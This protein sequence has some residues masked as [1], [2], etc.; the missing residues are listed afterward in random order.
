VEHKE[1]KCSSCMSQRFDFKNEH[2]VPP[3]DDRLQKDDALTRHLEAAHLQVPKVNWMKLDATLAE[4]VERK[5]LGVPKDDTLRRDAE[6]AITLHL[7]TH[8]AGSL[9]TE[10]RTKHSEDDASG[11]TEPSR[12]R[13]SR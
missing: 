2:L 10:H 7:E 3:S 11:W 13:L 4:S 9:N 12:R 8:G 5:F 6:M 1:E